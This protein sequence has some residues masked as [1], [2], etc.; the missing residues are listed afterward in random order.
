MKKT[1]HKNSERNKNA[2]RYAGNITAEDL[3]YILLL[4]PQL[5]GELE[6]SQNALNS[7]PE[8]FFRE[9]AEKPDW[10][11]LYELISEKH[12]LMVMSD[13]SQYDTISGL[14]PISKLATD[15]KQL[16]PDHDNA[17]AGL[18]KLEPQITKNTD[19]VHPSGEQK[20]QAYR[21]M[22]AQAGKVYSLIKTLECILYYGCYLNTLIEQV[23]NGDDSA[24]FKAIRVDPAVLGCE[25]V[26][27]RICKAALLNDETFFKKLKAAIR[28]KMGTREQTNF[29][30]M[31]MVLHILHEA[32]ETHLT[33]TELQ[34]LLVNSLHLYTANAHGGGSEKSLRKF[35][36]S[37][38]K[39]KTTT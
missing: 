26:R 24:L 18:A 8:S 39:E 30:N 22:A 9:N 13:L 7:H 11:H 38:M 1:S 21:F 5:R 20:E 19:A 32:G 27:Q 28:G 15:A 3:R 10:C 37:L 31:R 35:A 17:L 34:E 29:Q 14:P 2:T 33:N 4:L 23:R 6:D 12:A 36:D 16:L 25:S